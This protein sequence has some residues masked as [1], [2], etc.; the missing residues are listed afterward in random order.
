VT[1]P[2]E[3]VASGTP[4]NAPVE[5]RRSDRRRGGER[6][7]VVRV[8]AVGDFHVGEEDAGSL[9]GMFARV[10]QEADVLLLAGDITRWGTPAEMRVA[11]GEMADIEI[12]I[13]AVLGNHD[14]ESDRGDEVCA[15]LRERG[16]HLLD[17]EAFELTDQVG[18]AGVKGF[19]GGF[20]KRTLT[21]FGEPQLKEFVGVS[22][23]EVQKLEMALRSLHTPIRIA[24]LHYSPI[25]DT[26]IGEPEQ[27][28]PFLGTDRLAE[29]LDRYEVAVCFHGHAHIGTFEGRTAGGVPVYNVCHGLVQREK[30][31]E[32]YFVYEIKV[33]DAPSPESA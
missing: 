23:Q 10:N 32:M 3:T 29:P 6:P 7:G 28:Y 16:V 19:M 9:R 8:A 24:L 18:I 33:P 22:L 20:G 17:G 25:I 14:Y 30:R 27:I 13:V 21:A 2:R 31:G 15:I 26:V 11:V 5:R 1:D 4:A 12:P